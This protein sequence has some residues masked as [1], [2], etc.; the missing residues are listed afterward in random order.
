MLGAVLRHVKPD[1]EQLRAEDTGSTLWM[2]GQTY[3]HSMA[4]D[5]QEAFRCF[6]SAAEKGHLLSRWEVGFMTLFGQGVPMDHLRGYALMVKTAEAGCPAAFPFAGSAYE[7]GWGVQQSY[8]RAA[9]WYLRAGTRSGAHL[10][11]ASL[12][13]NNRPL[14]CAPLGE[15][16]PELTPLVPQQILR[17]MR[18]TM[19]LCKRMQVPHGVAVI[20]S[21]YVCTEGGEWARLFPKQS[22][23]SE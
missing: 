14:Q 13:R 9:Q 15:W 5:K 22:N 10:S 17:A 3:N 20:V 21:E 2:L 8:R 18:A 19:L 4:W 11:V 1:A 16:R 7:K 12:L 6:S 23:R